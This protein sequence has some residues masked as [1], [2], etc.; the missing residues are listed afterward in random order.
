MII[1]KVIDILLYFN[2]LDRVI[3][4]VP[5]INYLVIPEKKSVGSSL[6]SHQGISGSHLHRRG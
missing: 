6:L 4:H 5:C 2:F 3:D 1:I